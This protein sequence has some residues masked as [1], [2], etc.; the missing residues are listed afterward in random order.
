MGAYTEVD[1]HR[2]RF[3]MGSSIVCRS[4][5]HLKTHSDLRCSAHRSV[6]SNIRLRAR[7]GP[8]FLERDL[9]HQPPDAD[10]GQ[11]R[12]CLRIHRPALRSSGVRRTD[13]EFG[14]IRPGHRGP[15]HRVLHPHREPL[16]GREKLAARS[17]HLGAIRQYYILIFSIPDVMT[18]LICVSLKLSYH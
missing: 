9:P 7:Q 11:R 13:S 2:C 16:S 17:V 1:V 18:L 3:L 8:T 14:H 12:V 6:T 10:S 15:V 4:I 5:L